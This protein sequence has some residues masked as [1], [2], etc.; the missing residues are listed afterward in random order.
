MK[1]PHRKAFEGFTREERSQ[2][3]TAFGPTKVAIK[4][5]KIGLHTYE[6]LAG[7]GLVTKE[8]ADRIRAAMKELLNEH[9]A[10]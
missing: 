3:T 9:N 8:T 4:K 10:G 2:L 6:T 7:G 5:L 1:I